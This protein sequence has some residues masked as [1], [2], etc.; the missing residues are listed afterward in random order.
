MERIENN[1]SC[2]DKIIYF[3]WSY[4]N[5]SVVG[6]EHGISEAD[7]D[8]W[9]PT[10][11]QVHEK[12]VH[13]RTLGHLA[14]WDVLEDE[15]LMEQVRAVSEYFKHR[16]ID[17]VIILGIG[18]SA[19]G[20][21]AMFDALSS[22]F[23]NLRCRP[24]FFVADNVDPMTFSRL[25]ELVDVGRTVFIV[26]SKSGTTAETLSQFLVVRDK[27]TSIIGEDGFKNHCVIITDPERGVLRSWTR[28]VDVLSCEIPPKL[29]GRFSVLSPVGFVPITLLG[30]DVEMVREGARRMADICTQED[31]LDNPAYKNGLYHIISDKD[32]GKHIHVYWAYA[33]C[34]YAFADWLRQLIAES[35][36]K[37]K[38]GEHY[39]P[40]PVKARGVTDQHSQLQLYRE[41]P[42]D[43]IIT[44]IGVKSWPH[45]VMIPHASETEM[46]D[47]A[48]LSG[49]TF[50]EL[51]RA[52]Q[53]ATAWSLAE[54]ER[55]NLTLWLPEV[56]AY[57]L[58]QAFFLYE[59]QT[60]F[61]GY[62][63]GINPF[64]QP[65]VELSKKMTY[66]LM[67]RRGYEEFVLPLKN[68]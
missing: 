42:N 11:R 58:G 30:F 66:G 39:G 24:R 59:L 32:K 10:A 18:G 41:G 34:L 17:N 9:L 25:I 33:D 31:P 47:A 49:H 50:G 63:Y 4:A 2:D 43:K 13:E 68:Q 67:G 28:A 29:G 54:S 38:N 5:A 14:F 65:G 53:M 52:E 57:T 56:N 8:R 48:Y 55:P 61:M 27:I 44:F 16:V 21:Q 64:D 12:I 45:D 6:A 20:A 37:Q 3:D 19:L 46:E 1:K 51:L 36:G 22:P 7:L 23:Y 62:C 35:L 26:V 40:T 60:V 15:R